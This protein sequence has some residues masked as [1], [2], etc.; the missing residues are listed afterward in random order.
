MGHRLTLYILIGMILGV[1]TGYLVRVYVPA[2]SEAFTYWLRSFSTLSTIFLN[3]IK[4][5]VAPLILGTLIAGIA[6]MGDSS[7]LGRIGTRAIAWFILASLI[8]I[9]LGLIMVNF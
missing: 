8:S 3:L 2:D 1:I 9:S 5:V 6:H 4:L 7:A